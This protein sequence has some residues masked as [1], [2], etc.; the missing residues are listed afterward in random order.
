MSKLF[1]VLA[2][3][4]TD[5]YVE[6]H[7]EHETALG[8]PPMRSRMMIRAFARLEG[9]C[10][11]VANLIGSTEDDCWKAAERAAI[12]ATSEGVDFGRKRDS[13]GK[14]IPNKGTSYLAKLVKSELMELMRT[15]V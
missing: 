8:N 15:Q 2:I 3:D 12:Q 4:L 13:T 7:D 11:V 5:L 1:E 9:A 10:Y 6:M 14:L